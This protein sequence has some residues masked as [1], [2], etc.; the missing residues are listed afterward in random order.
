VYFRNFKGYATGSTLVSDLL[1]PAWVADAYIKRPFNSGTKR[2]WGG[3][4]VENR[5]RIYVLRDN[6]DPNAE[7]DQKTL[8]EEYNFSMR[9]ISG[10]NDTDPQFWDIRVSDLRS[11]KAK[12]QK[13]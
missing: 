3:N 8:L 13:W 11:A 9:K 7:H 2:A 6:P 10:K 1:D 4:K 12:S 5:I